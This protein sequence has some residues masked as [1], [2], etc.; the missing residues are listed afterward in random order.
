MEVGLSECDFSQNPTAICYKPEPARCFLIRN[1][2]WTNRDL[3][4]AYYAK[5]RPIAAGTFRSREK[6][7]KWRSVTLRNCAHFLSCL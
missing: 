1:L 4:H 7:T 6:N 5:I 3:S 2:A